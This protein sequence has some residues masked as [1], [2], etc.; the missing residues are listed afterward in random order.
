MKEVEQAGLNLSL[1]RATNIFVSHILGRISLNEIFTFR[2]LVR[3]SRPNDLEP[4]TR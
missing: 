3:G 4:R 1:V 2:S